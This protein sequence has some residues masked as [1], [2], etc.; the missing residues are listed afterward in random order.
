MSKKV[1]RKGGGAYN[2]PVK[3]LVVSVS[4]L[5]TVSLVVVACGGTAATP[6][7]AVID[8]STPTVAAE[9]MPT[10]TPKRTPTATPEPTPTVSPTPT[11]E[12]PS[13]SIE[14]WQPALNTTWQWQ[15]DDPPV[16]LS[17]DVAM[18][19]IDL[20][21][22]NADVVETLHALGRKVVCYI[23][24][25][26]WEIWRPDLAQFPD[27]VIGAN[28]DDWEGEKWLDIR[29]IDVLGPI[30]EARMDLCKA[31]GFDGVEPDNM[32]GYLND[33]GFPLSYEDQLKY[34]IWWAN[35]AHD[36]GLSIGLKNDLEQ[37]PDLLPNF[38]WALNE[39][40]FEYGECEALLPF[41]DA[42]KPVFHVEYELERSEFC[43]QANALKFNSLKKNW[44]LD[45][46][47]EPCQCLGKFIN[48][49]RRSL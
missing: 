15:L 11:V 4:V 1:Y 42:G 24:A 12:P 35:E 36:R 20:F 3:R 41:I 2:K 37:I 33:T 49:G 21:D 19:D 46:W 31:K 29:R 10:A 25:G 23:N 34:N 16:D 43:E 45:A 7:P 44:D 17:F 32:D 9:P 30:M 18:Y 39:Q 38:D 5:L 26:G 6:P 47:Q 8:M 40:C 27:E 13:P 14:I 48:K 28:L 22:N